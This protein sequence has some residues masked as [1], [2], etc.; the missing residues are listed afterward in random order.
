MKRICIESQGPDGIV[1]TGYPG[2]HIKDVSAEAIELAA[3]KNLPVRFE[4]NGI[5]IEVV[6][7]DT[8]ELVVTRFNAARDQRAAA[9]GDTDER[10]RQSQAEA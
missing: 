10:A 2:D 6:G 4:F 7:S 1:V 9:R 3:A 5:N 8:S